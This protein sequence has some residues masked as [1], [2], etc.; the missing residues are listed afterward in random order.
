MQAMIP[1][2]NAERFVHCS[3]IEV[4]R[5]IEKLSEQLERK[6]KIPL[7]VMTGDKMK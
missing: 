4:P 1:L 7:K 5:I 3:G 2:Q 6:R